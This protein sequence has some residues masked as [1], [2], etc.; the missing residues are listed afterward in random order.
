MVSTALAIG[1]LVVILLFTNSQ[2]KQDALVEE[3]RKLEETV[4]ILQED[5][6]QKF[7]ERTR[8]VM[9]GELFI[10]YTDEDELRVFV[11]DERF[12]P[13]VDAI[14]S[15]FEVYY[16]YRESET[17]KLLVA[18]HIDYLD[19]SGKRISWVGV[20]SGNPATWTI[21]LRNGHYIL[22]DRTDFP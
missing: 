14:E 15:S 21:E 4:E 17:V 19:A 3:N 7:I 13:D 8:M 5:N 1:L 20:W 11:F 9:S 2:K 12:Y 18:Y 6:I 22:V 10:D 16:A